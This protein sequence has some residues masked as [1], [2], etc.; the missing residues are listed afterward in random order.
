MTR[1]EPPLDPQLRAAV[2][3][4]L[5]TGGVGALVTLVGFGG[6]DAGSVA[7]GSV[8]AALNLFGFARIAPGML[9]GRN[10]G[11][12]V[13]LSGLKLAGLFGAFYLLMKFAIVAPFPLMIGYGA[14]PIG[15]TLG[16]L[17]SSPT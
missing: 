16:F 15:I 14:L 4:I 6:H 2:V 3:A 8:L 5:A 13:A 9:D 7:A 1:V 10:P 17:F 12:T 11:R